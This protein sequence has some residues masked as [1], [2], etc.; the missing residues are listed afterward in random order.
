MVKKER[1][2]ARTVPLLQRR[3]GRD[4]TRW[5]A[6]HWF[7]FLRRSRSGDTETWWHHVGSAHSFCMKSSPIGTGEWW[8][9]VCWERWGELQVEPGPRCVFVMRSRSESDAGRRHWTVS[10]C[11]TDLWTIIHTLSVCVAAYSGRVSVSGAQ[12]SSLISKLS[13]SSFW[14]VLRLALTRVILWSEQHVSPLSCQTSPVTID[15]SSSSHWASYKLP[16][17]QFKALNSYC[18]CRLMHVI[19]SQNI[20]FFHICNKS[21]YYFV[22][23][24]SD[25]FSNNFARLVFEKKMCAFICECFQQI[26][27]CH[28]H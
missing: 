20:L 11:S 17:K 13:S 2:R 4:H 12:W 21:C 1:S 5:H 28:G 27:V 8:P 9:L 22:K 10:K 24:L 7:Q 3:R 15:G 14:L 16:Y 23:M 6:R 18:R 25:V 19:Y 26:H